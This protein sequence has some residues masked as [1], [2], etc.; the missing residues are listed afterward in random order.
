[1]FVDRRKTYRLENQVKVTSHSETNFFTGFTE[2]ITEGGLFIC[3]SQPQEIGTIV[4]FD[5]MVEGG[6]EPIPVTGIVRWVR[7]TP[8]GQGQTPPGMGIQFVGLSPTQRARLQSYVSEVRESLF[9]D[10]ECV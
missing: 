10:L 9:F 7:A 1:M 6:E 5:L 4:D 3:T 2:N 8:P